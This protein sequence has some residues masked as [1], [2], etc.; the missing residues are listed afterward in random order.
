M[1][2]GQIIDNSIYSPIREVLFLFY[3]TSVDK[4]ASQA[5]PLQLKGKNLTSRH[6]EAADRPGGSLE[7]PVDEE[8]PDVDW[9]AS[10]LGGKVREMPWAW[11]AHG[12]QVHLNSWEHSILG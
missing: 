5:G 8:A 7:V 4:A 6:G 12:A 10:R 9:L 11:M 2:L 1:E 3:K